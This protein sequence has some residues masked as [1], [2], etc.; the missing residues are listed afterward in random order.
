MQ[1]NA[2]T[3]MLYRVAV[4]APWRNLMIMMV[5]PLS[6]GSL[7]GDHY[8]MFLHIISGGEKHSLNL[9]VSFLKCNTKVLSIS[10]L[11]G[12]ALLLSHVIPIRRGV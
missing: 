7:W 10:F 5:V 8:K 2:P 1:R 3:S 6:N 11:T 12:P 9:E 4:A